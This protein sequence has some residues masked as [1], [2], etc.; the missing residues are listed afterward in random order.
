MERLN[1]KGP[2]DIEEERQQQEFLR[3]EDTHETHQHS[4]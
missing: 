4:H 1:P 2:D 3:G